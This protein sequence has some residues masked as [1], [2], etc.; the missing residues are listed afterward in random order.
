MEPRGVWDLKQTPQTTTNA[1]QKVER[2]A[3]SEKNSGPK[4]EESLDSAPTAPVTCAMSL[5]RESISLEWISVNQ[6]SS[7]EAKQT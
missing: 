2:P 3:R 6:R 1:W 7:E 4:A 5:H